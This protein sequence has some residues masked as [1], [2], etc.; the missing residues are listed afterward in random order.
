VKTIEALE[1]DINFQVDF[2]QKFKPQKQL[3]DQQQK[4]SIFCGSGDSLAAAFL[5]EAF[6]NFKV[7]AADP[8]DLIKNKKITKNNSVY[9]ISI[10][11]ST[12]SNI[13][14][15]KLVKKT[16]AISSN[17]QSRLGKICSNYITLNYQNTGVFT[18]GSI[19][20][21]AS[22]L[23][24]ISLVSPV[25]ISKIAQLFKKAQKL[26][27]SVRLCGKI[28]IIGNM[29][30]FP[31]TMYSAAKFYEILGINASYERIEQ[32]LHMGLFSAKPGDT[33]IIFEEKN[34]L[35]VPFL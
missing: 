1:K 31:V 18:S 19:G 10:S 6:S 27:K 16:T 14:L 33:V 9:I 20:F 24:C 32:F 13:R 35:Q 21:L 15:A 12:I 2:L 3:S 7:R 25:K 4:K 17:S 26:S 28:F 34:S 22:A 23:T 29:H 8:L 5:A 11:G 30:T